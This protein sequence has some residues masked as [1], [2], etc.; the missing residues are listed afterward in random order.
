LRRCLYL[1]RIE[2]T[3]G[4][5]QVARRIEAFRHEIDPRTARTFPH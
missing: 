5:R 2:N 4:M 1:D 3:Y